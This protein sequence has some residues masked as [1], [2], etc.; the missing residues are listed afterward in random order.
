M[1]WAPVRRRTVLLLTA[2]GAGGA[3]LS[4][5][6]RTGPEP[7][8]TTGASGTPVSSLRLGLTEWAI[9]ASADQVAPGTV[10]VLVTNAGGTGHDVVVTG[11]AGEWA[12]P[13]LGPGETYELTL[14]TVAGEELSLVCTVAGHHAAGMHSTLPVAAAP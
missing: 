12:T 7:A 13:V 1:R 10:E 3:V 6:E 11:Q 8:G 2:A 9:Q 14:E 4:A 5:C